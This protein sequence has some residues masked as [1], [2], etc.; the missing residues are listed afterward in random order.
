MHMHANTCD[1]STPYSLGIFQIY[2]SPVDRPPTRTTEKLVRYHVATCATYSLL[3]ST[4][5]WQA[6]A[7]SE[8]HT[9]HDNLRICLIIIIIRMSKVLTRML[10]HMLQRSRVIFKS[11]GLS[12]L[13]RY[14]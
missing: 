6:R 2:S 7:V 10:M 8:Q 4:T 12:A 13:L 5:I 9:C 14:L 11:K 1:E 3:T